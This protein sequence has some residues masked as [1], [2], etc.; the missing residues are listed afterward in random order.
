VGPGGWLAGST[1]WPTGRTLQPLMGWLHRHTLQEAVTRNLKL[2]VDGSWT[3][4]LLGHVARLANQHL[5]CQVGNSSLDPYK[6]PL[7]MKFNI[8]HST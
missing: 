5:G 7:P 2:E 4:W 6:Y 8:P 3:Q 1:P